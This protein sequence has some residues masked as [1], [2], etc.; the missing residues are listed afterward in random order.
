MIWT[1]GL[2]TDPT[3][4]MGHMPASAPNAVC[5]MQVDSAPHM[6]YTAQGFG[7]EHLDQT[8]FA[9]WTRVSLAGHRMQDMP[10]AGPLCHRNYVWPIQ[11]ML[12]VQHRPAK[13][14]TLCMVCRVDLVLHTVWGRVS[15]TGCMWC[16]VH[17]LWHVCA[18]W[19]QIQTSPIIST[20]DQSSRVLCAIHAPDPS[21]LHA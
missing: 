7:P 21:V 3:Y 14:L 9:C 15:R 17:W 16:P 12:C 6:L 20:Q 11:P 10:H 4:H 5:D 2:W 1:M 19:G 13:G 18:A 8:S